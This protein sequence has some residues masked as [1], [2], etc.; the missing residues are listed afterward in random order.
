M[1][2]FEAVQNTPSRVLTGL[3]LSASAR[4]FKPYNTLLL[5]F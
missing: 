5:V 4:F 1:R 2:D 3:K